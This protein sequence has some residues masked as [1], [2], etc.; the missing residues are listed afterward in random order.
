VVETNIDALYLYVEVFIAFVAFATIVATIKQAFGKKLTV[1]C[2][3]PLK[4]DPGG[5]ILGGNQQLQTSLEVESDYAFPVGRDPP[6]QP[7][8]Q[9]IWL[10]CR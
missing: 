3:F 6:V 9:G 10:I 8:T 5:S 7:P 4:T 2:W 1:L